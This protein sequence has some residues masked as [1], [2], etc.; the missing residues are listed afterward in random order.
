MKWKKNKTQTTGYQIQYS[1]RSKF[2]G[3]KTVTVSKNKTTNK[4]IS[5]LATKKK[6]YVRI[7]TYKKIGSEKILFFPE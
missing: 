1:T 5:K 2:K 4:M 3:A 6:H 7:R